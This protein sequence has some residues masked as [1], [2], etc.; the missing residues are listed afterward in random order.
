LSINQPQ[1]VL[2][3]DGS[4]QVHPELD[5]SWCCPE[6]PQSDGLTKHYKKF[7]NP[8]DEDSTTYAKRK[9]EK[10]ALPASATGLSAPHMCHESKRITDTTTTRK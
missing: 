10:H 9:E 4:A 8:E 5:I 7:S 3:K 1:T 2:L 6:A